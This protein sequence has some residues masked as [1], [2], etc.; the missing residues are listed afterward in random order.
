MGEGPIGR[1]TPSGGYGNYGSGG[2]GAQ[3]GS[4]PSAKFNTSQAGGYGG[5]AGKDL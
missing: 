4:G 3:P 1:G 2:G 5:P